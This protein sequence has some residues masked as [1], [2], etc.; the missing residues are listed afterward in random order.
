M[1]KNGLFPILKWF[2]LKKVKH[3]RFIMVL[4]RNHEE[5]D[6]TRCSSINI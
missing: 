5:L 6:R 2:L 1:V 3:K 4:E